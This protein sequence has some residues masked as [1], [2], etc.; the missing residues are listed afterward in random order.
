MMKM[1]KK[2]LAV[3]ILSAPI[4][5][6]QNPT[7]VENSFSFVN[8]SLTDVNRISCPYTIKWFTYSKEKEIQ[9]TKAN[10]NLLVKIIPKVIVEGNEEKIVRDSFPRELLVECGNQVFTLILVPKKI[11][12]Q[13]IILKPKF[14]D[15]KK[16]LKFE[17]SNDY[18]TTIKELIKHVYREEPPKGYSVKEVY[19]PYKRFKQLNMNILRVYKG[20]IYKI[21]EYQLIG[22]QRVDLTE[23][24]FIPY[25]KNPIAISLTKLH[26]NPG[27]KA[28]MFVIEKL[29]DE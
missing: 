24:L 13:T 2:I 22:K 21:T 19:K 25:L 18:E 1:I 23:K 28:R 11:P 27:E 20:A 7:I 8:I 14:A 5:A 4:Y 17:T 29:G 26:L 9:I 16:A 6:K 15:T 12:T 10:K 3:L